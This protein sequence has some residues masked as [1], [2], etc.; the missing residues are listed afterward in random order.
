MREKPQEDQIYHIYNRGVEKR[1]IFTVD[2][3]R[4]RFIS[5]LYFFNDANATDN[6][7]RLCDIR[8]ETNDN[9]EKLVEIIAFVLMDNHF[10]LLI[11]PAVENGV[12]VFMQKLGIGYTKY[13]NI[14]YK[15]VGP[16]FQGKYKFVQ[17][18]TDEQ[19]SYIPHYIHLNPVELIEPGWKEKT[20]TNPEKAFNFAK[21]YYWSSLADYLGDNRFFNII[22]KEILSEELGGSQEYEKDVNDWLKSM[23]LPGEV[24][25]IDDAML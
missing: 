8:L 12:S 14:K 9:R 13:F 11:K 1:D 24:E 2:N 10:H 7:R 4:R 19:L 20:I 5:Y 23:V 16:L 6:I 25:E 18:E 3:D 17:I 21:D 22:D 15:R